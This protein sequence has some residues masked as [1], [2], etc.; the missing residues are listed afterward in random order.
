[1]RARGGTI[2]AALKGNPPAEIAFDVNL[3]RK[4]PRTMLDE[5]RGEGRALPVAAKTLQV[6]DQAAREGLGSKDCSALMPHWVEH[7]KDPGP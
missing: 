1:L 2:A 5:A 6:F 7:G 3:I 4:D